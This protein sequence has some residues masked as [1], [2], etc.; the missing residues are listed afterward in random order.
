MPRVAGFS[1]LQR[2]VLKLYRQCLREIRKKPTVS[3]ASRTAHLSL[4][5]NSG[6]KRKFQ[7]IYTVCQWLEKQSAYVH[8]LLTS[9]TVMNSIAICTWTRRTLAPLSSSSAR[10][11]GNWNYTPHLVL[12]TCG[13]DMLS[14]EW[15]KCFIY[16]RNDRYQW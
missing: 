8:D 7:V 10:E 1:G 16:C 6:D 11:I 9:G 13:D 12:P 14:H 5:F 15:G 3:L 4:I 2:D